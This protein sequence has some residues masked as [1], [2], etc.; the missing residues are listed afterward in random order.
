MRCPRC[1][2]D[3]APGP[4][5]FE[6][7]CGCGKPY[8]IPGD[9][10]DNLAKALDHPDIQVTF[11]GWKAELIAA[12]KKIKELTDEVAFLKDQNN[13]DK[14]ICILRNEIYSLS[15]KVGL[16]D[17]LSEALKEAKVEFERIATLR[18][19]ILPESARSTHGAEKSIAKGSQAFATV[20]AT[21]ISRIL[22][23]YEESK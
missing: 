8:P 11:T 10:I 18:D 3:W 17:L 22:A 19:Q 4:P 23:I 16:L 15:A 6:G 14:A 9:L 2:N 5:G 21:E 13:K 20:A 1:K 7:E 12:E